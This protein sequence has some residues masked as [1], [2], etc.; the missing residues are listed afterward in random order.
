MAEYARHSGFRENEGGE[1]V[2]PGVAAHPAT[3]QLRQPGSWHVG[4]S[5]CELRW[6]PVPTHLHSIMTANSSFQTSHTFLL[7]ST[8]NQNHSVNR[9]WGN[10]VPLS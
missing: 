8:L 3:A 5:I 9:I 2:Q 7:W 4:D 1:L 10:V 6:H